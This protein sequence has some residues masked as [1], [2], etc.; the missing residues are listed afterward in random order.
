MTPIVV[1]QNLSRNYQVLI[2]HK[3]RFSK[4]VCIKDVKYF[5]KKYDKHNEKDPF[6]RSKKYHTY[7]RK[8]TIQN[9]CTLAVWVIRNNL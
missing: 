2:F 5:S 3:I 7:F 6:W 9:T 8:E 4:K 1:G